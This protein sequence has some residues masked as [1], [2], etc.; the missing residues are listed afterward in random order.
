MVD[1]DLNTFVQV[2]AD[3]MDVDVASLYMFEQGELVLRSTFGLRAESVGRVRM[4][5]S[6][7]LTGSTFF[8][9]RIVHVADAPRHPKFLYFPA[10]GEAAFRSFLGIPLPGRQGVL[11][12][13]TR[14]KHMFSASE[15]RAAVLWANR[16]TTEWERERVVA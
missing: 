16:I 9:N 13:Q 2:A 10:T 12:F 8:T 14:E 1:V 4:S 5:I 3:E 6:Q 15:I 11:V 7:G